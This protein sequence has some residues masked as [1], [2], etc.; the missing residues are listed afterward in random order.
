[1]SLVEPVRPFVGVAN[2]TRMLHDPLVWISLRN[3][4]L[5][6]LYVPVC[7]GVALALALALRRSTRGTRAVRAMFF[8]ASRPSGAAVAR[9][10]RGQRL[11]ALPDDH[12]PPAPAGDAVRARHRDHR[13]VSGLHLRLRAHGRRAATH[14]GRHR[15]PDLPGRLGIP[16]VRVCER[17]GRAA[18]RGAVRGDA[19]AVQAARQTGRVW[20]EQSHVARRTSQAGWGAVPCSRSPSPW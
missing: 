15:L 12:A 4:V 11:A 7:A 6:V 20:I 3:T 18:V 9:G 2:F 13:L 5:Y 1:W 10:G 8:L 19:R 16:A 14:H 17:A